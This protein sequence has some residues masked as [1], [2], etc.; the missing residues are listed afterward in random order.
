MSEFGDVSPFGKELLT[1]MIISS[2]CI[3]T[4]CNFGYFPF[5][6][7]G[8]NWFRIASVPGLCIRFTFIVEFKDK[9]NC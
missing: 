9:L 2:F 8:W 1:R 6:F 3:L 7:E 5:G 4:H